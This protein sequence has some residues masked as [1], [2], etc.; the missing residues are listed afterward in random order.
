MGSNLYPYFWRQNWSLEV[1]AAK[2]FE[3][4][5]HLQRNKTSRCWSKQQIAAGV[6]ERSCWRSPSSSLA[7]TKKKATQMYLFVSQKREYE[8][9]VLSRSLPMPPSPRQISHVGEPHR[10]GVERRWRPRCSP[11]TIAAIFG[12][13]SATA[14]A[15]VCRFRH[16]GDIYDFSRGFVALGLRAE[17]GQD[18]G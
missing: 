8:S 5:G 13:S 9:S 1:L 4:W 10:H 16:Q 17:R 2:F 18:S 12:Y 3:R 15:A 7:Q 14:A 6:T 11:V